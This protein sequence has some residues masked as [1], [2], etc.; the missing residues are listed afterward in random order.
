MC[1]TDTCIVVYSI[2]AGMEDDGFDSDLV[3]FTFT[4]PEYNAALNEGIT[5]NSIFQVLA[6]V[7][8]SH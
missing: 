3:S 8:W 6:M 7:S 4:G 5:V 1:I 2:P